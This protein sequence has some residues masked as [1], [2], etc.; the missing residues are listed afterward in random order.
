MFKPNKDGKYVF[1]NADYASIFLPSVASIATLLDLP[2]NLSQQVTYFEST[3]DIDSQISR[4]SKASLTSVGVGKATVNKLFK[5]ASNLA[6]P[7]E[8][9]LK[10]AKLRKSIRA[11]KVGSNAGDWHALFEGASL[12]TIDSEFLW[13]ARG[14]NDRAKADYLMVKTIKKKIKAG[15]IDKDDSSAIWQEQLLTWQQHSLV[16]VEQLEIYS[17]YAS[18]L[19]AIEREQTSTFFSVLEAVAH[20][21]FD[22]YLTAVAYY[23]VGLISY[24][25]RLGKINDAGS[26]VSVFTRVIATWTGEGHQCTCYGAVLNELKRLVSKGGAEVGWRKL[27]TFIS[28]DDSSDS[29]ESLADRQYKQL[30]GWRN[31]DNLPSWGR[32][33]KFVTSA[34]QFHGNYDVDAMLVYFRI[35]RAL[36]IKVN[37][38]AMQSNNLEALSI[39]KRALARYPEYLKHYRQKMPDSSSVDDLAR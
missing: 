32:L 30:K 31:G 9:L 11:D 15:V 14:F 10:L 22:F 17:H 21:H 23:E 25:Q 39:W 3:Y 29:A 1:P 2:K 6:V 35:A 36:D 24:Y 7:F 18:D 20:L 26:E 34:F 8:S 13:L 12:S 37:R 5:M 19:G 4:S 16:P 38:W 28:I 27:A 33:D